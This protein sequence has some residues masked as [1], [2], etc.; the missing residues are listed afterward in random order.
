MSWL[1]RI[2]KRE[3]EE[4]DFIPEDITIELHKIGSWIEKRLDSS[5]EKIQPDIESSME[6]LEKLQDDLD[7]HL[8]KL[9]KEELHNPNITEREI[10]LMEGNRDS[11]IQHHT[12]FIQQSVVP[13]K[14]D[15]RNTSTFCENFEQLLLKPGLSD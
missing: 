3:Q 11:Y 9:G 5:F 7:E 2:F 6:S 10:H 13:E 14:L 12:L 8:S 4:D 15:Y 1:R